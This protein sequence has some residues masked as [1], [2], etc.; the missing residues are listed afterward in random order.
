[1]TRII[2]ILV[3]VMI[4]YFTVKS[5]FKAPKAPAPKMRK[6]PSKEPDLSDGSDMQK[7]PVCGTYVD[8]GEAVKMKTQGNTYF[9]CSEECREKF[10]KKGGE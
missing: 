3:L 1:M 6:S 2:L 9:F 4:V 10:E 7:D 5:M 8:P